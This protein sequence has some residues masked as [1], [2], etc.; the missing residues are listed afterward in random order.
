MKQKK[1][2]VDYDKC[3]YLFILP[4]YIFFSLFVA[5]PI[6]INIGL[7]FTKFNLI[8][9]Q[10]VGLN[11]YIKMFGDQLF[12]ISVKNTFVYVV[13]TV[14][15]T[16][17]LGFLLALA[18]N[19]S[20]LLGMKFFRSFFY[21]PFVTSM[22]SISMVWLW[23]YEPSQGILNQAFLFFGMAP[24]KWLYDPKLALGCIIVMGIWKSMGYFMTIYI[25]GL[26]NIPEYLYEA[27][28]MDGANSFQRLR[29]ITLPMLQ[30]VTFFIMITGTINAFNV[31]EQ[32]NVM[33]N[34]GPLTL[35]PL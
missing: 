20:I 23:M 9:L 33:T 28:K 22:V 29:L 21:L 15:F 24:Q 35:Q 6:L 30:P 8:N 1:Y 34:G 5:A 7:S 18:L 31:F 25:A 27:A 2:S 14:L 16:M 3:G 11:N 19:N 13:F 10:F 17:L 4:F 32:V 26:N 12:Y